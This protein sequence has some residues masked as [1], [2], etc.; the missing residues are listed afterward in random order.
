[1]IGQFPV[2]NVTLDGHPLA[3][4]YYRSGFVKEKIYSFIYFWQGLP[5]MSHWEQALEQTQDSVSLNGL[6]NAIFSPRRVGGSI[7]G[8]EVEVELK[9]ELKLGV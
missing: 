5:G 9:L 1:M 7:W 3:T 6:R 2:K 4:F 8:V